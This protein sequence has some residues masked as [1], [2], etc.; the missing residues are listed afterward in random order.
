MIRRLPYWLLLALVTAA[1]LVSKHLVFLRLDGHR[2]PGG[3]EPVEVIP[4][5]FRLVALRNEGITFGLGRGFGPVWTVVNVIAI[6]VLGALF[7]RTPAGQRFRAISFALI[8]A[9]A[10]GNLYDRLR[11]GWVRDF[12]DV[13]V[14]RHHWPPF[15]VADASIVVGVLVLAVLLWRTAPEKKGRA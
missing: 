13:H 4:G 11:F 2:I 8:L 14:G 12:L 3:T 10:L 1:D 6:G 9:G 7:W 15:N 5:L